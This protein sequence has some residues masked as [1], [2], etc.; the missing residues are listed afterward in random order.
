MSELPRQARP[1]MDKHNGG[2]H[3][4]TVQRGGQKI[5]V[6][7]RQRAFFVRVAP[8]KS[9]HISWNK[10]PTVKDAWICACARAG[11]LP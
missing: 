3:S 10:F 6:L 7:L 1:D 5:E 2:K 4:Y 8:E 11:V 9:K